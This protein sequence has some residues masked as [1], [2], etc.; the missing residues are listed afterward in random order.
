MPCSACPYFVSRGTLEEADLIFL[1][2]NYLLDKKTQGGALFDFKGAVV[3][4]D[5]AHN[6][7]GS[8]YDA[9]SCEI[10]SEDLAMAAREL[11][12]CMELV[13]SPY[14]AASPSAQAGVNKD[15][16]VSALSFVSELTKRLY[17][18]FDLRGATDGFVARP[19]DSIFAVFRACRLGQHNAQSSD[20]ADMSLVVADYEEIV[21]LY[22]EDQ[23][24]RRSGKRSAFQ[25]I[26]SALQ[27]VFGV[28][29]KGDEEMD[30]SLTAE[31]A[32]LANTTMR[33]AQQAELERQARSFYRVRRGW[34]GTL[35]DECV[36]ACAYAFWCVHYL[37]PLLLFLS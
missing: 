5:E 21:K 13:D 2:Y 24:N 20:S 12:H 26:V 9:V 3:I 33:L 34:S 4:L 10:T 1:P 19:G 7:E 18:D 36:R 27:T 23:Y 31:E 37:S 28:S 14:F 6:V 17:D 11:K 25:I 32:A 30:D 22:L 15:T 16:V 35:N 8:C 29:R